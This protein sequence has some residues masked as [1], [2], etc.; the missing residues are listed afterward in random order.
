MLKRKYRND[1][2]VVNEATKIWKSMSAEEKEKYQRMAKDKDILNAKF[3]SDARN[4]SSNEKKRNNS[5]KLNSDMGEWCQYQ[6]KRLL[7][8]GNDCWLNFIIIIIIIQY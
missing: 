7:N 4:V 2:K 6:Y 8:K 3:D 5:K 1:E